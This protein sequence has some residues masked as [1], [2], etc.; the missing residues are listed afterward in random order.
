MVTISCSCVSVA[1]H[2]IACGLL[3]IISLF[4]KFEANSDEGF[5]GCNLRTKKSNE[6]LLRA[7]TRGGFHKV[8]HVSLD[9]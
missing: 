6:I 8:W 5:F 4:N 9:I 1:L 3:M 7:G 2:F